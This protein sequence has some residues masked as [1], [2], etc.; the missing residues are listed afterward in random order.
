MFSPST[1]DPILLD[2]ERTGI[3]AEL[4]LST[5]R[6]D[7]SVYAVLS[8]LAASAASA[9]FSYSCRDTREFRETY[10]SWLMLLAFRLQQRNEA[11]S[12]REMK[13][14]LGEPKSVVPAD[15]A[16]ALSSA[17]WWLRSVV[18]T[19]DDGIKI[20][21]PVFTGVALG[22][23]AEGRRQSSEFTEFDGYVPAAGSV[24]DP[25]A[26][27]T[28]FSVTELEKAAE[29]PFRFFLKRGLGMRP[30][31]DHEQDKDIWLDP[32]T[33]GSGVVRRAAAT[34]S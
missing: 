23:I 28:S 15:R 10:A 20:L 22:R 8:R 30:V 3:S 18:G 17:G 32:L 9:T 1:E 29:C 2:V 31:D 26:P 7:E 6:V 12:Y 33:R 11:L 34:R 24:L 5:D 14:A 27:E 25:C 13:V 4:R 16:T 19:G 21:C